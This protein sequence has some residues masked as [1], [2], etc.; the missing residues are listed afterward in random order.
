MAV[1]R[2]QHG[3][4]GV[5]ARW[6][7]GAVCGSHQVQVVVAQQTADRVAVGHAAAQYGGRVGAAVHQV[8]QQVH[9]VPAG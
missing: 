4:Q 5:A 8:A 7:A 1:W 2:V 6:F 9:S 3:A